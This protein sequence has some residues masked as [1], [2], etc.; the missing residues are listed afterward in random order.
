MERVRVWISGTPVPKGSAKYLGKNRKTGKALV[1]QD[2]AKLQK[3]WADAIGWTVG[4]AMKAEK[5]Q[6]VTAGRPVQLT[7]R[8]QFKRPKKHMGEGKNKGKVKPSAPHFHTVKPDLDK[9]VRCVKDALSGI[10]YDDDNQVVA[11]SACKAYSEHEGLM[12][13][14]EEVKNG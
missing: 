2:N 6:K 10:A 3:V 7:M 5:Q 13:S 4:L 12:L 8:F 1:V 11:H 14:I 9:L